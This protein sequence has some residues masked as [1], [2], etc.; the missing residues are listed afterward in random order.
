[1][2][3]PLASLERA[4]P[5]LARSG[6]ALGK[7]IRQVVSEVVQVRRQGDPAWWYTERLL[8]QRA[9]GPLG[10][11]LTETEYKQVQAAKRRPLAALRVF[12]DKALFDRHCRA[13]D[14][15][16][17]LPRLL[18]ETRNGVLIREGRAHADA[19]DK[20]AFGAALDEM[21]AETPAV[22]AKPVTANK[23]AGTAKLTRETLDQRRE[24]LRL[25]VLSG[26]TLFQEAVR[27]HPGLDAFYPNSL[28]TLR[29]MTGQP[30]GSEPPPVLSVIL[31][32]GRQGAEVDNAHAGGL[33]VGVDPET[34]R[35]RRYAR[36]LF[37]HGGDCLDRHPDTGLV[38]EGQDVPHLAEATALAQR[39]Q[40]LSPM[41]YVGWDVGIGPGGPVLIEGNPNPFLM[42]MEMANGGFRSGSAMTAFLGAHGLL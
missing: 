1:M 42:M 33:F 13:N 36:S 20:A 38:F 15:G 34:N 28:N 24:A 22:F 26:D 10:D 40:A 19:R 32:M 6:G 21:L 27:Q 12:E 9:A 30:R 31:R 17:P 35:L 7:T 4:A 25:A 39:A 5:Y 14:P 2:A 8:Y 11:Y 29:L 41:L 23:G 37:A 16:L 18:A 3:P